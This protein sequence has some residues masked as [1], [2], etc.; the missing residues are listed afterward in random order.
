MQNLNYGEKYLCFVGN[1]CLGSA[2]F[3][4]DPYIGD[5]FTRMAVHR[6]R[7]L[8]EEILIPE[9]VMPLASDC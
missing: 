1:E 2:T 4:D 8:E 5:S 7:G 9:W 3:V 6:K